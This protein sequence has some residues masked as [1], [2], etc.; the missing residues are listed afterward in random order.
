MVHFVITAT[1][2]LPVD[3]VKAYGVIADYRRGHPRILP[4]PPFLDLEVE[5]GGVGAGTI[6]RFRMRS[7][8][9]TQ[10]F[11]AEVTEPRPGR[12]LVETDLSN[13]PIS[14]F[15][16]EPEANVG[17]RVTIA[18]SWSSPPPR[19]WVERLLVPPFLR[20]VYAEELANLGKVAATWPGR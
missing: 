3:P 5:R 15:T 8:G 10:T 16:V 1:A 14:T 13:G 17:S 19:G 18:T 9:R 4:R 2:S 7:F 6:I 11:R 20:R 12:V